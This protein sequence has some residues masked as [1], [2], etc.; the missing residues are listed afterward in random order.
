MLMSVQQHVQ[1]LTRIDHL[2][3]GFRL[4]NSRRTPGMLRP[5]V[6]KRVQASA[7]RWTASLL[8][9]NINESNT[10]EAQLFKVQIRHFVK[11]TS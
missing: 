8:M 11:H 4:C 5:A 7:L 6:P 10:E 1:E 2:F 9:H 3:S